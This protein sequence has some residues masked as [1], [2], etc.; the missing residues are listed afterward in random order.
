M[1]KQQID[2]II[3]SY[4]E[5]KRIEKVI[6]ELVKSKKINKIIVVDDGSKDKTKEIVKKY[7]PRV[8]YIANEKNM[9]KGYSMNQG[10][11]NSKARIIV[12]CDADLKNITPE[13]IND[14]INNLLK[15]D[16]E[17]FIANR[18]I[19]NFDNKFFNWSGQR[20][21]RK[22]LWERIPNFYK[23]GFR[24]EIGMNIF[25]KKYG[26]KSYNYSQTIKESKRGLAWGLY[27]R[28]F[29]YYQLISAVIRYYF[30]DQ[31]KIRNK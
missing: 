19:S 7:S 23:K 1:A 10:V 2:A 16:Y 20:V 12:F 5:E 21:I 29:M 25:C 28:F 22:E 9:G 24:I 3:P 8:R 13:I 11:K 30:Y 4:K 27:R 15:G 14:I 26:H 17:M 6:K 31:F 18:K